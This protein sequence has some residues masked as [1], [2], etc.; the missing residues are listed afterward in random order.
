MRYIAIAAPFLMLSG[1]AFAAQSAQERL[2]EAT[3][4]FSEI[5]RTPDK[6]I[7]Q[8]L[9]DK[10]SCVVI[11]PGLKKGAFV[12][13]GEFG[14]GFAECRRPGGRGWGAPAAIRVEGGSFGF[15][16]GGSSTDI[17]MLV[18]NQRG[19]DRLT[20]DK[21][22]IGADAEAA[23]GPV[24][25][26]AEAQTD[27]ELHAEILTWSRSRGAFAG[28]SLKG[29]TMRPD[30]DANEQLYGHKMSNKEV[31]TSNMPVPESARPLIAELDRYSLRKEGSGTAARERR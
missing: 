6:G 31:L 3:A 26:T 13:G 14:K 17:V 22:T 25:R 10:S 15:Q 28:V 1:T 19:M 9:I 29:A 4:V 27:V 23:A 18:M 24:G 16:I 21:F 20:S 8:D 5:M 7:P 11:V 30:Q 12:V 2:G